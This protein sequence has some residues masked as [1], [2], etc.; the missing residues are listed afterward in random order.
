M[1]KYNVIYQ[2]FLSLA[3][4]IDELTD[5]PTMTADE[6]CLIRHLNNAWYN[7]HDITVLQTVR[8]VNHLSQATVLRHLK[9]LKNKGYIEMVIDEMDNRIKYVRPTKQIHLYFAE[10][11]K[12]M[13]ASTKS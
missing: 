5:F 9:N 4:A 13:I 1:P 8:K 11:G 3:H 12:L 6:K 7:K 2:K 10:H